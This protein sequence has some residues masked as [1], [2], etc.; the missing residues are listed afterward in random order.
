MK[1]YRSDSKGEMYFQEHHINNRVYTEVLQQQETRQAT[2]PSKMDDYVILSKLGKCDTITDS[3]SMKM[4]KVIPTV[5]VFLGELNRCF[6]Q[7]NMAIFC[8]LAALDPNSKK[9]LDFDIVQPLVAHYNPD[10]TNC[11]HGNTNHTR[12]MNGTIPGTIA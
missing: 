6:C 1:E 8:S 4:A 12:E 3:T 10:Q 2:V 7:E 11:D 9:F 5:D